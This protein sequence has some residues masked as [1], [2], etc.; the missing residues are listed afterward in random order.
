MRQGISRCWSS[1]EIE[2]LV[3]IIVNPVNLAAH[4]QGWIIGYIACQFC[5]INNVKDGNKDKH[6][7]I[8]PFNI[9]AKLYNIFSKQRFWYP[10]YQFDIIQPGPMSG[11]IISDVDSLGGILIST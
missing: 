6:T 3:L 1:K 4:S 9:H 7:T 8:T 10:R 2:A 5:K 11:A